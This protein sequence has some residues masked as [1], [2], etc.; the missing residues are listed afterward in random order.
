MPDDLDSQAQPENEAEAE[1]SPAP[2]DR[3]F[4]KNVAEAFLEMLNPVEAF[5][6]DP[7]C[8]VVLLVIIVVGAPIVLVGWGLWAAIR[9]AFL[10]GGPPL[11]LGLK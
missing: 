9:E 1:M 6:E 3:G 10:D 5:F 11:G 4:G 8:G 7:R 2:H